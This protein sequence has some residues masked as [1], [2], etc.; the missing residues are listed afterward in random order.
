[1]KGNYTSIY[2]TFALK[3]ELINIFL[4]YVQE[5]SFN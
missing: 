2:A 4:S 1:M 5:Q 3:S